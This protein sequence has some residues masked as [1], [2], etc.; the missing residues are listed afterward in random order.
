MPN[1]FHFKVLGVEDIKSF[2]KVFYESRLA[3]T[4]R[5]KISPDAN[6][7]EFCLNLTSERI[8]TALFEASFRAVLTA[9]EVMRF[10]ADFY[11][12]KAA[13]TTKVEIIPDGRTNFYVILTAEKTHVNALEEAF[14]GGL[15]G[16][17][18]WPKKF[19]QLNV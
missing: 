8:P 10:C 9:E 4:T 12:I 14:Y 7:E 17:W 5:V 2:C 19:R 16:L 11:D 15:L 3:K 6:H 18:D 1:H 13:K